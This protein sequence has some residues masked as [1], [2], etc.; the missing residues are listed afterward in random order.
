MMFQMRVFKRKSMILET[1]VFSEREFFKN[2]FYL[3][4]NFVGS[5][6]AYLF[7]NDNVVHSI[8]LG[9]RPCRI[10][11]SAKNEWKTFEEFVNNPLSFAVVDRYKYAYW[12]K[13]KIILSTL[14]A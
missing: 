13:D 4:S 2:I 5:A 9:V 12:I 7:F 11:N 10:F 3:Q 1:P 6:Q 8:T 14:F